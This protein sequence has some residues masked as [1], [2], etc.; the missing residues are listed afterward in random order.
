M[1]W[2][3]CSWAYILNNYS[4][5]SV[6]E[7]QQEIHCNVRQCGSEDNLMSISK[8]HNILIKLYAAVKSNGLMY[9]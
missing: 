5:R 7:Q 1:S 4:Q 3:F 6:R 9:R 2:K 8:K